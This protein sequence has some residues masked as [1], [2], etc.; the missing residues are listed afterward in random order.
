MSKVSRYWLGWCEVG[1]GYCFGFGGGG[2]CF[3][4]GGSGSS[5]GSGLVG[6]RVGV[7][8]IMVRVFGWLGWVGGDSWVMLLFVEVVGVRGGGCEV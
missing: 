2:W 1:F 3:G 6:V 7:V 8:K 4:S 5:G